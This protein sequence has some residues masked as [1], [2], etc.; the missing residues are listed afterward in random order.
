MSTNNKRQGT[1]T[2]AVSTL[3]SAVL[4]AGSMVLPGYSAQKT[5]APVATPGAA[6]D[7]SFADL[8]AQVE[9]SVVTIEVDKL[10]KPELSGFSGEP[11]TEEFFERF[12]GRYDR[13]FLGTN[14]KTCLTN[15][16]T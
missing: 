6:A 9:P 15:H 14:S 1:K 2:I 7:S 16:T 12:F 11:R 13:N 8:I 4:I 3:I 5:V 10:V